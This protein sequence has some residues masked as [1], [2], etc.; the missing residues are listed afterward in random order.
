M[1]SHSAPTQLFL[2]H[3]K[4]LITAPCLIVDP[5]HDEGFNQNDWPDCELLNFRATTQ[6]GNL[7]QHTWP[8]KPEREFDYVLIYYPKA[9]NKL[10]WLVDQIAACCHPNTVIYFVG[11]NKGGIKSMAKMKSDQ[12]AFIKKVASGKHS[13]IF[14]AML[15][16]NYSANDE[17][18]F[19]Q[20][21]F[22]IG[23]NNISVSSLPSVFSDGRL[24][25]GTQLLLENLPND[26]SGNVLD[27]ASGCGVIGSYLG[28]HFEIKQLTLSDVDSLAVEASNKS[29]QMNNIQGKVI[30][31][32]GLTK[33]SSKF[34]WIF[35]NPPFHTGVKIDYHVVETFIKSC[36]HKLNT[37]GKLIL[38][39]NSFLKYSEIL[40]AEFK[41]VDVIAQNNKFKVYSCS[42]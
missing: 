16:E 40:K 30:L 3:A 38:V 22:Q 35:T 9:K 12:L 25:E 34:D 32:D 18:N 4:E 20:H 42:L 23:E 24:D 33:I 7:K 21:D 19:S 37:Q 11:E 2:Q 41:T 39:A 17:L 31:S 27:F 8:A 10:A 36:R 1:A 15:N 29:L 26:I 5:I 13:L 6:T 28:K 14:Q